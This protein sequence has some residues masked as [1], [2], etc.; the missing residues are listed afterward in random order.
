MQKTIAYLSTHTSKSVP[1]IEFDTGSLGHG[2]GVA[3]G[4]AYS[5]KIE[6]KR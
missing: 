3:C 4:L 5:K 1:G 2:L 6:K